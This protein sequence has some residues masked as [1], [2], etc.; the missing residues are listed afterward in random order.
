MP[1]GRGCARLVGGAVAALSGVLA[2]GAV[3]IGG[4]VAA[5]PAGAVAPTP[6]WTAASTPAPTGPDTPGANPERHLG[7]GLLRVGGVL[8]R[9]REVLGD[10]LGPAAARAGDQRDLDDPGGA[11]SLQR[12]GQHDGAPDLGLVRRRRLCVAVGFYSDTTGGFS[13]HA[14]VETLA[15]GSWS[16]LDAPVPPDGQS[17]SPYDA[18]LQ[19]VDCTTVQACVAVGSY[20]GTGGQLGLIDTESSGD[21]E[22]AGRAATLGCG[23]GAAGVGRRRGVPGARP[24]RGHG[25]LRGR[26]LAHSRLSSR[27]SCSS[28]RPVRGQP[29][30]H[31]CRR[32]R[33]RATPSPTSCRAS[34]APPRCVRPSARWRWRPTRTSG[35]S[36]SSRTARG[37]RRRRPCPRTPGPA[38]QAST[39]VSCTFDGICTA[40]GS[41]NDAVNGGLPLID[42]VD[43]ATVTAT[44]G[45]Q[46]ADTAT[47]SG[48]AGTLKRSRACP[49]RT[50]PPSAT[51]A[52]ARTR[53][54]TRP[55]R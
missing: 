48:S 38:A 31:P 29:R 20:N 13:Q 1:E 40:V 34:R 6:G 9:G 49:A 25:Q 5:A 12:H 46:P 30:T 21:L 14:L 52:T 15:G 4:L 24:L 7:L 44:E 42:T 18:L 50:A 39:R 19:S 43:G 3:A 53:A 8:R 22:R 23:R 36:S 47:G 41:Y 26:E 27:S 55:S 35:C 51:T 32:G 11:A 33:T 16:P 2:L 10:G 28:R 54:W 45:P 17:A 37:R